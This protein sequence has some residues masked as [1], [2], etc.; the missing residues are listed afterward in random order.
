[1]K[2]SIIPIRHRCQ[3]SWYCDGK[4]DDMRDEDAFFLAQE[5]AHSCN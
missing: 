4:S 1:M 3:F 5:I 2:E